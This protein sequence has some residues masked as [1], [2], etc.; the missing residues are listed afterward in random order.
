M[1]VEIGS[2]GLVELLMK[3][4]ANIDQT[5]RSG[6]ALHI[7]LLS[8]KLD[9]FDF[10]LSKD[11][12]NLGLT[13]DDGQSILHIVAIQNLVPEAK[14]IITKLKQS[15]QLVTTI[16]EIINLQNNLGNTALHESI[17][18]KSI[19]IEELLRAQEETDLTIANL[20][21]QT[22]DSLKA[23]LA[24][25][26][27]KK[28][29]K[30]ESQPQNRKGG[31]SSEEEKVVLGE[32]EKSVRADPRMKRSFFFSK[33]CGIALIVLFILCAGLYAFFYLKIK[34]AF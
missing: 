20:K 2:Q 4:G 28:M 34:K 11:G 17:I 18:S 13:N 31:D 6:N 33:N 30:E 22:A 32:K 14:K 12:L 24:S 9:L 27:A 8:D 29:K 23:A 19:E 1:A 3:H 16:R 15:G 10:F 7:A 21:G 5:G 25:S 26:K